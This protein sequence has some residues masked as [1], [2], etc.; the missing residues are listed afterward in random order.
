M[1]GS[2]VF[3][4]QIL[5]LREEQDGVGGASGMDLLNGSYS[6]ARENKVGMP[7]VGARHGR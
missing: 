7:A 6:H 1:A 2:G 4:K 5:S 3:F